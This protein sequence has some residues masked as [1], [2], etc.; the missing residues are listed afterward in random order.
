MKMY[1]VRL[2]RN[3]QAANAL[4]FM[5]G[6]RE[7]AEEAWAGDII[8]LHN[9]G[10]IQVGDTFTQGE[11][12]TYTGIPYFAPELFRRVRLQDPLKTKALLKGLLQLGEEGATQIFRPLNSND[13]I[14]G[15]VGILQFDV[16]AWRLQEEYSVKCIYENIPVNTAR[17]IKCDDQK[18]LDEFRQKAIN[19]LAID[20]GNRLAYLAPSL[21]NLNL[22]MER[23]PD[24][25]FN[26]TCEHA[27]LTG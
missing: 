22:T 17:W 16:V 15:A 2:G 11:T 23:W 3:M 27:A 4:T 13:L 21:V 7:H 26:A 12:L 1:H 25:T 8:G 9:H 19:H 14:L 24:I 5:A 18:R 20:G 10:T 6:Q